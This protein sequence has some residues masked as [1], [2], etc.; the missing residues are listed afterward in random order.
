MHK[1]RTS[2]RT[3]TAAKF[4]ALRYTTARAKVR[5]ATSRIP[6]AGDGMFA[7][8]FICKG[9]EIAR[10]HT[11]APGT[12]PPRALEMTSVEIRAQGHFHDGG[13]SR[14]SK[15][16]WYYIN[17]GTSEANA[18]LCAEPTPAG[19]AILWRAKRDI[20]SGEEIRFNYNP[21]VSIPF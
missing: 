6:H 10:M 1:H 20:A 11:A 21:G 14:R 16:V 4:A 18:V 9:K 3:R 7:S 12:G 19:L 13:W 2:A 5:I 15:P 8:G 17:H